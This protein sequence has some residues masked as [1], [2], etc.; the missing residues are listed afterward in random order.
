MD[1]RLPW[2]PCKPSNLLGALA[3]MKPHVGYTY[4]VVLLRIYEMGGCCP[5]AAEAMALRTHLNIRLVRDALAT[6][7]GAGKLVQTDQ[8]YRNPVAD[9]VLLEMTESKK[10]L[11]AAGKAGGL[12]SAKKRNEINKG[13]VSHASPMPKQGSSKLHKQLQDSPK[14]ESDS[15]SWPA[16][17][18]E[19]FWSNYPRKTEKKEALVKLDKV[20]KSG[21]VSWAVFL[22]GVM[23]HAAAVA[24][25]EE[26]YIKHPTTWLHRGC[27]DDVYGPPRSPPPRPGL[28]G[29]AAIAMMGH[30]REEADATD[31]GAKN[32]H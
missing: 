23:R 17:Y 4:A 10:R 21:T 13:T 11:S 16:D 24:T 14:G 20:R 18:R 22:A 6:L 2:F 32:H 9:S 19:Q 29:F 27:W 3:G 30:E 12:R 15:A 31:A 25:T 28:R 1:E 26:R 8:G 7:V 5:D